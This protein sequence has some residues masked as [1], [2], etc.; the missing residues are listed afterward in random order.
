MLKRERGEKVGVVRKTN[1]KIKGMRRTWT[2]LRLAFLAGQQRKRGQ[3]PDDGTDRDEKK[4][5]GR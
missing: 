4:N 1:G 2:N 5:Q 3:T